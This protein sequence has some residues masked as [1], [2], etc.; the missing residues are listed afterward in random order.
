M[1]SFR[2]SFCVSSRSNPFAFAH[3]ISA[4]LSAPAIPRPRQA[5]AP[6]A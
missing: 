1:G 2:S 4:A 6:V 5:R 3:A